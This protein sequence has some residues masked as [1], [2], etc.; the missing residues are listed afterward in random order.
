MF[1]NLT[2]P[3]H[4]Y[5]QAFYRARGSFGALSLQQGLDWQPG[6]IWWLLHTCRVGMC[7]H[8]WQSVSVLLTT[9]SVSLGTLKCGAPRLW[10]WERGWLWW[11]IE[12]RQNHPSSP[13]LPATTFEMRCWF[14]FLLIFSKCWRVRVNADVHNAPRCDVRQNTERTLWQRKVIKSHLVVIWHDLIGTDLSVQV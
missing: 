11:V 4:S 6:F 12:R 1:A 2:L 10:E 7:I 13:L 14:S 8:R 3:K 5:Y 9:G